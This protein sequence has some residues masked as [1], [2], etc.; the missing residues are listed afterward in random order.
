MPTRHIVK[1]YAP[2]QYYHVFNRG[3]N[4][5]KIFRDERDYRYFE[6]LL[7]RHISPFPQTDNSGKPY[8]HLFP[9]VHLNAYC[10]MENH[11]HILFYQYNERGV[12]MIMQSI[13]TA[14]TMYF[15]RKYGR[16]GPLFES[17]FKAVIILKDSQLQHIT[18]YI[19]LNRRN[20]RDW[21]HSSYRDYIGEPRDWVDV[22][23]IL[24]L[25]TSK[26]A[27]EEFIADYESLQ[28]ER[29]EIKHE[30]YGKSA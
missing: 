8:R 10:L 7:E 12:Q 5:T 18:R 4:L 21:K 25:F 14:Y 29:D 3:W 1:V 26:F 13:L 16:R 15:N 11:F 17:T 9:D 23:P 19:H 22:R 6:G 24:D 20:Y 2:N 30:M 27:Y 28:R